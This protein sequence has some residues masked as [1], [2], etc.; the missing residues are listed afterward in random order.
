MEKF[1]QENIDNFLQI[2]QIH[3]SF[4]P[5]IFSTIRYTG[6]FLTDFVLIVNNICNIFTPQIKGIC[7]ATNLMHIAQFATLVECS[8]K[9]SAHLIV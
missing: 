9:L 2:R 4:L 7:S 5:P 8:N 3:P 6:I 1:G